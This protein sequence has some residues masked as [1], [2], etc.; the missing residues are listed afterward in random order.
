MKFY[1]KARG[2]TN[3][4]E[5]GPAIFIILIMILIP[6]LDFMQIGLAYGCGWYA[7]HLA[8]REASCAGPTRAQAAADAAT[9]AWAQSGLGQFV[10]APNP[11]NTVVT[12]MGTDI[13]GD[14][15]GDFCQ[16][17]TT[18]QVLPMFRLPFIASNP[19][20][21]SYQGVRPMEEKNL[22]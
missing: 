11:V 1:R 18:V 3:T 15:V 6:C 19:I 9:Q 4:V 13:D 12:N 7:N 21:F 14:G 10:H 16:V 5:L 17:T 22:Q 8:L 20:V 2:G